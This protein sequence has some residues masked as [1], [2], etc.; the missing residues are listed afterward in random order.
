MPEA[1]R[2]P[3]L[4]QQAG[5][6]GDFLSFRTELV[7]LPFACYTMSTGEGNEVPEVNGDQAP[8]GSRSLAGKGVGHGT[9]QVT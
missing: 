4:S 7:I 2:G 9:E 1:L 3:A 8:Q 6:R 5:L